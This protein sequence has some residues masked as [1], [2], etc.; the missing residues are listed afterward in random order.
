MTSV[1]K[2]SNL[3]EIH[4]YKFLYNLKG[5]FATANL[6]FN[7]IPLIDDSRI[8][9]ITRLDGLNDKNLQFFIRRCPKV[10]STLDIIYDH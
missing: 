10:I 5:R 1:S 2:M 3:F 7:F 4:C 9:G 6:E 8:E